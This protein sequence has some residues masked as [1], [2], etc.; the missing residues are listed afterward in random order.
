MIFFLLLFALRR[1]GEVEALS[2]H[3]WM[4]GGLMMMRKCF[5]ILTSLV[6]NQ[7]SLRAPALQN[8]FSSR[9]GNPSH[10]SNYLIETVPASSRCFI[11]QRRNPAFSFISSL[12]SIYI[13]SWHFYFFLFIPSPFG[14]TSSEARGNLGK[15]MRFSSFFVGNYFDDDPGAR[16]GERGWEKIAQSTQVSR[17]TAVRLQPYWVDELKLEWIRTS[18][19][20][21]DSTSGARRASE[22][23]N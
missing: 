11:A 12:L 20:S 13:A 18:F 5:S 2:L 21:E 8:M 7:F 14:S 10:D 9:C 6:F 15:F 16:L 22:V 3:D 4:A 19:V 17:I 23:I 1:G